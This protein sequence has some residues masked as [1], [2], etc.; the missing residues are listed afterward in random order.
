MA[1]DSTNT[2]H[3]QTFKQ[4]GDNTLDDQSLF[5][6]QFEQVSYARE[7]YLNVEMM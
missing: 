7:P 6:L 4:L 3:H 1:L 5:P 2:P